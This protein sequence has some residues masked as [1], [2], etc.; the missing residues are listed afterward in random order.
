MLMGRMY[1]SPQSR[2]GDILLVD[3]QN[4][5]ERFKDAIQRTL[6]DIPPADLYWR[7]F[8][9]LGATVHTLA[10]P[11]ILRKISRGS[12]DPNNREAALEKLTTFI[13]AGIKVPAGAG[14]KKKHLR[15]SKKNP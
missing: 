7:T 13:V 8:F 10:S 14:N 6:P 5:T 2:L 4:F 1:S 11:H 12:C 15:R 3:I 9:A